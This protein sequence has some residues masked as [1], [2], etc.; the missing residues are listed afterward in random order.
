M[1]TPRWKIITYALIIIA[2]LMPAVP[3][4]LTPA[5]LSG[6]PDWVSAFRITPGLDLRGGTHL[7][8]EVDTSAL[9]KERLQSLANDARVRLK[10]AGLAGAGVEAGGTAVDITLSDAALKLDALR[11]LRGLA[12]TIGTDAFGAG[13]PELD[14]IMDG[15][16]QVR[17]AL[18]DG[19]VRERIHAAVRQSIEII[20]DRINQIGVVEPTIQRVGMERILV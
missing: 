9:I 5:Q 16:R 2:G 6:L 7:V 18:T 11:A 13:T 12:N 19:G 8:L 20:R 15:E 3:N 1:R 10:H 4:L 17:I 14:I